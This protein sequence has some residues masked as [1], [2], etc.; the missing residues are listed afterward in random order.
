MDVFVW[1]IVDVKGVFKELGEYRIDLKE[2]M[3]S[4][5]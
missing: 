5:W 1:I 2:D 3:V 4:V